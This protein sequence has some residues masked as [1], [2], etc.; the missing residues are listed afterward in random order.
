MKKWKIIPVVIIVFLSGSFF[1]QAKGLNLSYNKRAQSLRIDS[2]TV[3]D[4]TL[5]DTQRSYEGDDDADAIIT[6]RKIESRDPAC[7]I[8]IHEHLTLKE[9]YFFTE[10]ARE[11]AQ[12]NLKDCRV[13]KIGR[14]YFHQCA[15]NKYVVTNSVDSREFDASGYESK[16]FM[17]T[18]KSCFEKFTNH[19]Q[20]NSR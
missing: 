3:N 5:F 7:P 13:N 8:I 12:K 10:S 1:C 20:G 11:T 4:I 16:T 17:T 19:L 9:G 18:T 15:D 14:L 6:T 2:F